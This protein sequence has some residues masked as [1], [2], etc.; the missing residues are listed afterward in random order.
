MR[1]DDYKMLSGLDL[2][3]M[4]FP[5]EQFIIQDI[6]PKGLVI[7]SSEM[8][9]PARS[10][11]MDMCLRVVTGEKLWK[12]DTRQGA[13]LYMI[14]QHTLATVRNLITDMTVRIPDDLYVGVM[15]ESSLELALIGIKT[16]V[17]DHSNAAMV[18]IELNA[19]VEQY[20]D[21]VYVSGELERYFRA[22]KDEALKYGM[23]IAVIL[24]S[25]YYP[26]SHSKTQ[27]EDKVCITDKADGHID[28][29]ILDA[30]D[31]EAILRVVTPPMAP[32]LWSFGFDTKRRRWEQENAGD[33]Q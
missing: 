22:L 12:M 20:E 3:M 24:C 31:R 28:M 29:C 6:V 16:F 33:H 4:E 23:A 7:L 13:V 8:A 11:A 5:E 25:E 17:Q 18:V 15:E 21:A 14:H 27:D 2:V 32:R 1:N 26:V 9:A 10:L 30:E 19:P